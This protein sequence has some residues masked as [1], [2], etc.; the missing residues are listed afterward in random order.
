MAPRMNAFVVPHTHWDRAWYAPFEEF[1]IRLVRLIDRLCDTLDGDPDFTC[2]CLDGQTVV[3]EDYLA[4]RPQMEARLKRLVREGRLFVGPWY[5]LP[6]QYLVSAESLVRNLMIGHAVSASFGHTMAVGYSPDAFGQIA[7]LPQILRGFGLDNFVFGR[8]L[9][10]SRTDLPVEFE[11][12]GPD[13]SSLVAF[14]MRH[15]YN[16]AAF[17]GYRIGW[18]DTEGMVLDRALAMEQVAR[19][20]RALEPLV[21]SRALL[22]CNGVDHSEHQPELP[23]LI[24]AAAARFP[25]CRFRIAS[26]EDYVRAAMRGLRDA[27]RGLRDARLKR[28][29]GEMWY[30]YGDLLRGVDSS[31]MYLKIANQ[32]CE[33]LLERRAEPLSALAWAT[34]SAPYAKDLLWH[35]WRE[36]LKNHPH[37]DICGCSGDAV[38][39]DMEHRF[40][41]V[42]QVGGVVARDAVRAIGRGIDHT[43]QDGVPVMVFNPLGTPR[44]E[45]VRIPIDLCPHDE[46]W[47]RFT[48]HDEDGNEVPYALEKREDLAW[49]EILKGVGARRHTIRLRLA[50]PPFGYRTLYVRQGAPRPVSAAIKADA[51]S[52]ENDL[53]RLRF[54]ADGSIRMT[55]KRTGTRFRNLLVFEEAADAGD[56]YNWSPLPGDAPRTTAGTRARI[57]LVYKGPFSA[58]WQVA[59][60]LRVPEGLTADRSARAKKS[61]TLEI[62]SEVTCRAA[63]P[64]IDV[65]TR[66]ENTARD[67]RVRALFPTPIQADTVH[68]DGHYAVLERPIP[69]P[70]PKGAMPPY[71]TQHQGR[72]ANVSDGAAGLAIINLGL[73]EFEAVPGPTVT[74]A[75]TLFRS[76]GWISCGDLVT[77]PGH[78]GPPAPAPEGQCLRPMQF[79]YAFMAH[80]GGWP[81]VIHEARRHNVDV[82]TTRCDI[83]GGTDPR[84]LAFMRDSEFLCAQPHRP[85]PRRGRLPQQAS[86]IDPG[87]EGIVLSAVKKSEK[88]NSLIVRLYNPGGPAVSATLKAFRPIRAAY[89]TD[90]NERRLK[91]LRLVRG[92]IRY[93]CRPYQVLTFEIRL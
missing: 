6:D 5:V 21:Q 11:W 58:T 26:F 75:Q 72:F 34:G 77:R 28:Y 27:M 52:F 45:V 60:K 19:A 16:N 86:L 29:S 85:V 71:P 54:G 3:L 56:E 62:V 22:L 39:R 31:R 59:H 13:G 49:V 50:L 57:R 90:L 9:D 38:H 87:S 33:D 64:R 74:L 24:R 81:E 1:R 41:V 66:I 84:Q 36:L 10:V 17:L 82:V 65:V 79:R 61:V 93:R 46:P 83:S 73:P 25:E 48:L 63:S 70:P 15:W 35:A 47:K 55:D 76:T 80:P 30:P 69:L 43:P 88:R 40:A 14:H 20:C 89:A 68:V 7:Q 37:D 51:R 91:P 23:E 42:R 12:R 32:E 78:T 2:F 4:I 18:G 92:A 8:G 67:H 44:D 53:F